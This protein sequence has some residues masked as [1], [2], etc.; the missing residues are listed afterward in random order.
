MN[1]FSTSSM[2]FIGG[3]NRFAAI[4]DLLR[5]HVSTETIVSLKKQ[6]Q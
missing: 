5:F 2:S 4:M 3:L 1:H 6:A